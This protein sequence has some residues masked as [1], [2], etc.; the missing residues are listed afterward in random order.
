MRLSRPVRAV[1]QGATSVVV[2]A[3]GLTVTCQ[4]VV[5]A[6]PPPLMGQV[7]FTPQLPARRAQ[8]LQ[9][10]P[11]GS[12]AKA[13]LAYDR[14]FWRDAGLTGQVIS[15]TPPA[16]ATFDN[17][18]PDAS[19][20][21]LMGF[22]EAS[23]IRR[24]DDEPEDEVLAAVAQNMG[25]YFGAPGASPTDAVLQRWDNEAW[26]R[27]GPVASTGTGVLLDHGDLVRAPVDRVHV[28]GT[29][30]ATWWNGYMEGAVQSGER[31]A[32]EVLPLLSGAGGGGGGGSEPEPVVPEAPRSVLL[33][34][35]AAAVGGGAWLAARH[36]DGHTR[37]A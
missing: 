30:T 21:A 37:T 8:L 18:P 36:R 29:E 26:S 25:A 20:G 1:T 17:S 28:A 13:V 14:P 15:D 2:E 3:D 27:G 22:L 24:L 31:A 16:Q 35:A 32:A 34:A 19:F 23:V 11:M 7:R 5:M 33:P 10:F 12:I 9:K 4:R 6:V